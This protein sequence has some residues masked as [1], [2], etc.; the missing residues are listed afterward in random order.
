MP[1]LDVQSRSRPRTDAFLQCVNVDVAGDEIPYTRIV[2]QR[3]LKYIRCSPQS[4]ADQPC[5]IL[6]LHFQR[7]GSKKIITGHPLADRDLA[8]SKT[9]GTGAEILSLHRRLAATYVSA[10]TGCGDTASVEIVTTMLCS[11]QKAAPAWIEPKRIF[12]MRD[13]GNPVTHKMISMP[14]PSGLGRL[15]V[16]LDVSKAFHHTIGKRYMPLASTNQRALPHHPA[17]I[18]GSQ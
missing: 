7:L 14:L 3:Y 13:S 16:P 1:L 9:T 12:G 8:E 5:D 17:D 11:C 2:W 10:G 18:C 6:T 4:L 15:S